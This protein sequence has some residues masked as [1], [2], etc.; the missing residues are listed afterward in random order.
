MTATTNT[1]GFSLASADLLICPMCSGRLSKVYHSLRCENQHSFDIA[2]EG[3]INLLL[4][5]H[6]QSKDPGDSKPMVA[7][8][9]KFHSLE[10]YKPFALNLNQMLQQ[11]SNLLDLGCG[12]GS[13]A[14]WLLS[15]VPDIQYYGVD[16]SRHAVK[17]ASKATKDAV[18]IV[19]SNWHLPLQAQSF[20]QALTIFAP[21][22]QTQLQSVLKPSGHWINVT[23]GTQ[24]LKELR[25]ALYPQ[26]TDI[27]KALVF[28]DWSVQHEETI[29]YIKTLNNP[30]ICALLEM[31]PYQ[32]QAD[33]QRVERMRQTTEL[34][35]TFDF[36][37]SVMQRH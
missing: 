26:L 11:G 4:P 17:A 28:D 3:Y 13:Y 33:Q 32:W 21:V 35:L 25:T 16:I 8:R 14:H 23:P 36:K 29:T 27:D 15:E 18:F 5:Q 2:K 12:E 37:V 20:D 30:S 31:T 1:A 22:N 24:H 9:R 6:K 19:A 10:F 34:E 7:A